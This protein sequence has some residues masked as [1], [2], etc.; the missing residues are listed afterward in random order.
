MCNR[1]VTP[2][3]VEIERDWHIGRQNPPRWWGS[4]IHPRLLGPF[5]RALGGDRGLVLGQWAL[6]PHFAKT[7]RLPHQTNNAR[8]EGLASKASSCQPW[9]RGQRQLTKKACVVWAFFVGLDLCVSSHS[10]GS[11]GRSTAEFRLHLHRLG[12]IPS[13]AL[14]WHP[15]IHRAGGFSLLASF[16]SPIDVFR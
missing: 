7:A 9:L 10:I 4:E 13:S 3:Q 15:K 14:I 8:V 6:I 1:Y 11:N 16:K 2:S 12:T 5:I